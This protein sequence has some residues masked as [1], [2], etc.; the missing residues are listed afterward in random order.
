MVIQ[1][2]ALNRFMSQHRVIKFHLE[3]LPPEA[4]YK[5]F[6]PE[7]FSIHETIAYMCR[8]QYVFLNRVNSMSQNLN[9]HFVRYRPEIDPQMPFMI[10]KRTGALMQEI[11]RMRDNLVRLL[12]ELPDHHGTRMGTHSLLGQMNLNQ[13]LD[14][15]LLHESIQLFK[16]FKLSRRFWTTEMKQNHLS[17]ILS[18]P[19]K[20]EEIA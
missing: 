7:G 20:I 9:P 12:K 17:K 18:L 11:N 5:V 19:G 6:E 16:I 4:I 15:F 10:S 13:W 14:F 2:H 8:Y 1:D 3:G